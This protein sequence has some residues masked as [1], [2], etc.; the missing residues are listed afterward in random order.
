MRANL[1]RS[2]SPWGASDSW[3]NVFGLL[4]GGVW[5][6]LSEIAAA[7][8]L[9]ER[10]PRLGT[11]R[12]HVAFVRA[13]RGDGPVTVSASARHVGSSFAVVEVLGRSADDTLCTISTVTAR[14]RSDTVNG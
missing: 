10:N 11:A 12:L 8:L 9:S 1:I 6:C 3:T 2:C 14:E 4:H 5:A 7:R 13:A